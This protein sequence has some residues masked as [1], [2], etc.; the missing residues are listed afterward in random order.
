M[1]LTTVNGLLGFTKVNIQTFIASGTYT[2]TP[3]MLYAQI[4]CVGGGGGG[5]GAAS[6]TAGTQNSSGGGGGAEYSRVIV[7][8]AQVG[9]SQTVTIGA[10]G[11]AGTAGNN[12]GG[13]GGDTSVGT[14]CVAKGGG[15][16]GGAA[17]GTAGSPGA[18]GTGGTGTFKVEGQPGGTG[19]SYGVV[20]FIGL[21]AKGGDSAL[22]FGGQAQ[23]IS[24]TGNVGRGYGGGGSGSGSFNN[25][26]SVAGI[27]GSAGCVI[28][29]EFLR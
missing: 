25:G 5:G 15:G 4:E 14:L 8:N 26:G 7:T 3:G 22:G 27:G 20:T 13:N 6:S 9:A 23:T 21:S 11:A 10:A 24:L 19:V 12:N 29:T 16:G 17:A 18:R 1:G 2:P 28:I